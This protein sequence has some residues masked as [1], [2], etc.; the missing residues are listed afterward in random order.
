MTHAQLVDMARRWLLGTGRCC[1]VLTELVSGRETADAIGWRGALS[2]LVECKASRSDFLADK[3][4]YFRFN[5]QHGMGL[6]RYYLAADDVIH[7]DEV[8]ADWG[9]LRPHRGH[10]RLVVDAGHQEYNAHGEIALLLSTLRRL[11]I[12]D[13]EHVSIRAYTCQTRCTATL[14]RAEHSDAPL[15][16]AMEG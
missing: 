14:S 2:K 11:H 16:D 8:P 12:H 10:A 7:A 5:P 4:K 3:K 13:G 9:L 6:Y 15:L 1:V